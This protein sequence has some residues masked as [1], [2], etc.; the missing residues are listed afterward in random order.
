MLSDLRHTT[1]HILIYSLGN[2]ST[3]LIGFVLLPLYTDYLSTSEYGM[4]A[5]L[6]VT[7]FMLIAFVGMRQSTAMM[8]WGSAEKDKGRFGS[9][10]FTILMVLVFLGAG[11]NLIFQPLA[12]TFGRILF[13]SSE[14]GNYFHVLFAFVSFEVLNVWVLDLIRVK[15]KPMIYVV[16]SLIK[17]T[18]ILTLN[19]YFIKFKGLGVLG[20]ILSQFIGSVLLFVIS[21]RFV[22][23]NVLARI[24]WK[25]IRPM[26]NY[27]FPLVFTTIS[28]YVLSLGDRY[29]MKY[30]LDL[31]AVGVY[32]LGY[33]IATITNLL[34]IQSFQIGFLPIAYKM[35]EQK[36]KERFFVKSLTYYGFVLV[37]F[38]LVLSMFSRELLFIL[39]KSDQYL[40]AY[41]IVPFI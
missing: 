12:G 33:K 24:E 29:L 14:Y 20:I 23:K 19:I 37:L 16:L 2:L 13:E 21:I 4:L 30:M 18:V 32:A 1:K 41:T 28:M 40:V 5:I 38:S 15:G 36:N 22:V 8:R 39:S 6:E 31:D 25:E 17:F 34:I 3:K 27:G 10:A 11:F 26:F 35:Y 7:S 9:I